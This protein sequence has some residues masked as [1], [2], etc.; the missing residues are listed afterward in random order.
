MSQ[1]RITSDAKRNIRNKRKLKKVLISTVI[2][3][4][5]LFIVT[6]AVMPHFIMKDTVNGHIDFNKTWT[7]EEFKLDSKKLMLTTE[8]ELDIAAYEVYQECPKAVVIFISGIQNPSVTA[9]FGHAKMLKDNGYASILMEMRAHGESE[10]DTICL[11]YKE[12]LDTKAVVDYITNQENYNDIP[13]VV[14][15]VSMGGATAIN[16]IGEISEIDALISMSAFS[17]WQDVFYDNMLN[18]GAPKWLSVM[19]KPFVKIY[20]TLKYGLKSFGVSPKKEITKLNGRPALLIHSTQ[21]S[22]IPYASF[23]RITKKA[24]DHIETWTRQGDHHFIVKDDNFEQP[25]MDT[26]YAERILGFL[27]K[28]FK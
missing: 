16:S 23:E 6:L 24:P 18:M 14:Y 3:V 15:G 2:V 10:G 4:I 22:Q 13:I 17:S 19:E 25:E 7:A 20:T 12:Y 5:I 21:D 26:E 9:F 1:P 27:D 28:N 11:G 8:D